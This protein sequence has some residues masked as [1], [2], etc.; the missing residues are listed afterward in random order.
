MG[1]PPL[2]AAGAF[3]AELPALRVATALANG[4]RRGGL[5]GS[6]LC[7]ILDDD[8]PA[9]D[10]RGRLDAVDFDT[11]MRQARA[12]IVA[13]RRLDARTLAG[14]AAFEIATRARQAGVPA[15]A[16][17]GENRLGS[18]DARILDLQTILQANDSRALTAA[19]KALAQL[20]QYP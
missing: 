6:D 18:F 11:R 5:P 1:P 8:A 14:S 16:V 15:Y 3:S 9:D 10:V 12:V 17:T 19:G 7:P 4:L 20:L 13:A 2:V